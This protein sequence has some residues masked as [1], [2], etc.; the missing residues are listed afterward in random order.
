[1]QVIIELHAI[2]DASQLESKSKIKNQI[3]LLSTLPGEH[4]AKVFEKL[5]DLAKHDPQAIVVFIDQFVKTSQKLLG[6]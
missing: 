2:I 5:L 4:N 3:Q 6:R 1:M